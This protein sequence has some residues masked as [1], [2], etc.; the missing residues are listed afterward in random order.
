MAQSTPPRNAIITKGTS[1]D[2][3]AIQSMVTAAYSHYTAR[4]GKP[5][6][7]MTADYDHLLTTHDVFVLR[8]GGEEGQ[9]IGSIV[10]FSEEDSDAIQINNLVVDVTA[11]GRGYG[12]MLMMFAEDLTRQKGRK[13]LELYTNVK[14]HENI[15]LYVKL[16]FHET[17]RRVEDGFER[18]Y[19]RKEVV[20]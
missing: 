9:A 5:P 17:G 6:A 12:R 16:G 10:L 14:M 11:Q 8:E 1:N 15:G 2:V 4:I 19:F 18:V 3:L 20:G 13:A 7:P